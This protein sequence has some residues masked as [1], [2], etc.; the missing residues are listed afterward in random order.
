MTRSLAFG[1]AV[2]VAAILFT[3]F[4]LG[5]GPEEQSAT[6]APYLDFRR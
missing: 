2:I 4:S 5:D 3:L 6:V 1:C